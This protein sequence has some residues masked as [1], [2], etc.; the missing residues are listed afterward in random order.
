MHKKYQNII[1]FLCSK[2]RIYFTAN[3]TANSHQFCKA[4]EKSQKAETKSAS[5]CPFH[6]SSSPPWVVIWLVIIHTS[7]LNSITWFVYNYSTYIKIDMSSYSVL[8]VNYWDCANFYV[9]IFKVHSPYTRSVTY[10]QFWSAIISVIVDGRQLSIFVFFV[11]GKKVK[12][13][14]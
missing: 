1:Q 3:N 10:C 5:V 6:L 4:E 11:K 7:S 13:Y 8:C 9:D 14:C 12:F 2:T